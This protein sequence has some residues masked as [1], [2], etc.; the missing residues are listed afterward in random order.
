MSPRVRH[1]SCNS[2]VYVGAYG[3]CFFVIGVCLGGYRFK[4]HCDQS[5]VKPHMPIRDQKKKLE[6]LADLI[7]GRLNGV[8]P[9][10]EE[11]CAK[12]EPKQK[13]GDK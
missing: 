2:P 1:Y 7:V 12:F 4:L 3:N 13:G 5:S 9:G 10:C 8:D 6:D 11:G